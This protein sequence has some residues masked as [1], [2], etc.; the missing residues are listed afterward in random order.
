MKHHQ[1]GWFCPRCGYNNLLEWSACQQC[2][3]GNPFSTQPVQPQ[4]T[5]EVE[6]SAL[7]KTLAK[8]IMVA[9]V[10]LVAICGMCGFLGIITNRGSLNSS[11]SKSDSSPSPPF[12]ATP[13]PATSNTSRVAASKPQTQQSSVA[14]GS[15]SDRNRLANRIG[16]DMT[17]NR[18]PSWVTA[19]DNVLH[20]TYE[21]AIIDYAPTGFTN[22][23]GYLFKELYKAG[24]D[25]I[26]IKANQDSGGTGERVILLKD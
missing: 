14:R 23:Y 8:P 19:S 26:V 13:T 17:A 5:E 10:S 2:Q 1:N 4:K 15:S 25:T 21:S 9:I 20:V 16:R 24:F 22:S 18:V 11:T 6:K 3:F 7:T 12:L